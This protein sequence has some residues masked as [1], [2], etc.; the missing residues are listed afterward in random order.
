MI[1]LILNTKS[2][3]EQIPLVL[4]GKS[5]SSDSTLGSQDYTNLPVAVVS[6]AAYSAED[7][8]AMMKASETAD[9]ATSVP[10]LRAGEDKQKDMPPPG[11]AYGKAIVARVKQ[12]LNEIT[13]GQGQ[14]TRKGEV[15]FY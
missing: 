11:P 14:L 1:H 9:G 2:G 4:S 5:A 7:V 8:A 13:N 3:C 15:V 6:G 10:W 12:T